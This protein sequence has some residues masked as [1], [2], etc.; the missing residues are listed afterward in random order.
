[1]KGGLENRGY[2][3]NWDQILGKRGLENEGS[4]NQKTGRRMGITYA[5]SKGFYNQGRVSQQGGDIV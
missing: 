2:L 4:G 1:M 5:P 3:L